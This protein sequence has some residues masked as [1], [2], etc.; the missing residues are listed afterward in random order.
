MFFKIGFGLPIK[1]LM[2]NIKSIFSALLK[3]SKLSSFEINIG[4][5]AYSRIDTLCDL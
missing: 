5:L 1:G 4:M 3:E 2:Q